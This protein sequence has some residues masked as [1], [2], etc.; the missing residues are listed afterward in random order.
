MDLYVKR[1]STRKILSDA[2]L[3]THIKYVLPEN[4]ILSDSRRR[5]TSEPT[6]Y[7]IKVN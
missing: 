7:E 4:N 5:F 1:Y 2:F 3:K 6:N